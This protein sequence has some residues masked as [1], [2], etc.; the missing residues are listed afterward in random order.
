ME[1]EREREVLHPGH[2]VSENYLPEPELSTT[3]L[4]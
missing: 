3:I 4:G 1:R 2:V